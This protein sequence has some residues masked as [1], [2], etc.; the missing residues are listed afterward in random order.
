MVAARFELAR[1]CPTGSQ[2]KILKSSAL[3]HSATLPIHDWHFLI[4]N[5]I[6]AM[7]VIQ[8]QL[9]RREALGLIVV[10]STIRPPFRTISPPT[11]LS[12]PPSDCRLPHATRRIQ[13]QYNACWSFLHPLSYLACHP[14]LPSLRFVF[15]PRKGP[16]RVSTTSL[17][18]IFLPKCCDVP[19]STVEHRGTAFL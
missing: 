14:L 16:L 2:V 3:D 1:V 18:P 9:A 11:V 17:S 12:S 8:K 6:A 19:K 15:C 5:T 10:S 7:Q 4:C 13:Y